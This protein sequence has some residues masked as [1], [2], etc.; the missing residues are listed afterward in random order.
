QASGTLGRLLLEGAAEVRIHGKVRTVRARVERINGFSAHAGRDELFR[1]LSG[2]ETA[3]RRLFVTHGEPEQ[4]E[5]F[6]AWVRER[7]GWSVSVPEYR[8]AAVLDGQSPR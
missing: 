7:T 5:A 6:A 3:P 8:E 1:W 4:A 2:L